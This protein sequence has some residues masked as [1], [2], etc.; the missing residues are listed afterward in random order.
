VS[1]FQTTRKDTWYNYAGGSVATGI[2]TRFY[3]GKQK[4]VTGFAG[5]ELAFG[6]IKVVV[7]HQHDSDTTIYGPNGIDYGTTQSIIY[8]MYGLVSLNC[9]TGCIFH[10]RRFFNVGL[11]GGIGV[12]NV[13]GGN[14]PIG[15]NGVWRLGIIIGGEFPRLRKHLKAS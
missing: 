4:K 9:L 3:F 13:F 5:P 2:N 14:N 7:G 10:P 11:Q 12:S 1:Y 6:L 15:W 8:R